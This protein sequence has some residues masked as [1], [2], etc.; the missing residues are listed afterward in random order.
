MSDDAAGER[1][2]PP[3]E[4][5][6]IHELE[7]TIET[8]KENLART[9]HQWSAKYETLLEAYRLAVYKRFVRTAEAADE[10]QRLLFDEE[11]VEEGPKEPETVSVSGHTRK[12][13][14]RKP[15]DEKLP[16]EEI[17]HDIPEEEK[18]CAC[19]CELT[20]IG[21]EVSFFQKSTIF[22]RSKGL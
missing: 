8:L 16:R 5:E 2:L 14:G 20:K 3:E 22:E 21:E 6:Y 4:R 7:K 12:K 10:S 19:G 11:P 9:E 18:V 15:L 13:A 1:A 17:V